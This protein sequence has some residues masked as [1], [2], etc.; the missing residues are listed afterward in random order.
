MLQPTEQRDKIDECEIALQ[1]AIDVIK[2]SCKELG[3]EVKP[4]AA[5]LGGEDECRQVLRHIGGGLEEML[6]GKHGG[7]KREELDFETVD[8]EVYDIVRTPLPTGYKCE[9][10]IKYVIIVKELSID[11]NK[12]EREWS[13]YK[14]LMQKDQMRMLFLQ[15]YVYQSLREYSPSGHKERA[16]ALSP[17]PSIITDFRVGNVAVTAEPMP[18]PVHQADVD[19]SLEVIFQVDPRYLEK[20]RQVE[21][22]PSTTTEELVTVMRGKRGASV[23]QVKQELYSAYENGIEKYILIADNGKHVII[24]VQALMKKPREASF[25][26]S[27]EGYINRLLIHSEE[28]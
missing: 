8:T 7:R 15:M 4:W 16:F 24:N 10:R 5:V 23:I 27:I 11:L 2:G 28:G 12:I 21:L 3:L 17:Y 1:A 19:M 6:F 13:N 20:G 25:D 18:G 9:G 14:I 22:Y 26:K